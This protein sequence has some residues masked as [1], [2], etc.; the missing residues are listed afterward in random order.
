MV[1]LSEIIN[2]DEL[3]KLLPNVPFVFHITL[4]PYHSDIEPVIGKIKK[5]DKKY[6][7]DQDHGD[8]GA[9]LLLKQGLM[10]KFNITKE[11]IKDLVD[12]FFEGD[13]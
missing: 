8:Y 3:D 12:I 5:D 11:E 13:D 7:N 4:T 9:D 6:N 10:K 1:K 2:L